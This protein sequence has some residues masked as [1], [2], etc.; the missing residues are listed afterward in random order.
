[1]GTAAPAP[2]EQADLGEEKRG[3]RG[4]SENLK[5]RV[6]LKP[7]GEHRRGAKPHWALGPGA[8]TLSLVEKP[9]LCVCASLGS[10]PPL[11]LNSGRS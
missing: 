5:R 10:G 9:I 6:T 3:G 7:S 11:P 8:F 2:L 4:G 1:M